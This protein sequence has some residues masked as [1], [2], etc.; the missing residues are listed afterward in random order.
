MILRQYLAMFAAL[1]SLSGDALA[2]AG[3][4]ATLAT[5]QDASTTATELPDDFKIN[6]MIRSTVIAINQANKTANYSVLRGLG[7]PRFQ[8]ANST[9]KLASIFAALRKSK[10]DLSPVLFFT[11][12]MQQV[13]ALQNNELRLNGFFDTVPQ[14]VHF[15]F[16]FESVEGE[17]MIYALN[18]GTQ[19]S[20]AVSAPAPEAPIKRD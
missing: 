3:P 7:S 11:P 8:D 13:P 12:T 19:P 18:I 2:Q 14:R 4:K 16:L 6:M 5:T 1:I 10:F 17:W 9:E 15:D 20:P